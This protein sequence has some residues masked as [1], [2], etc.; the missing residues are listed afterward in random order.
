MFEHDKDLSRYT[1]FGIPAKA[2]LFAEYSS[3]KELLALSRKPEFTDN[4]ILHIGGGS[5]LLFVNDFDGLVLHSAIKGITAYKKNDGDIFVIAGA[6]EKWAD[7]VDWCVDHDL[8]GMECMAGIPGEVGAAPVQNVG[9]YGSEAQDVIHSVECF[10][11]QTRKTVTLFN[12]L[13]GAGK[14]K[15]SEAPAG[16]DPDNILGFGYRDSNFKKDWKGRF[17]VLRVSF[18]LSPGTVASNLRYDALRK[19]EERL[20]RCPSIRE[21]R[22]EVIALRNSKLPDPAVIGSAGSFFKNPVVHK[23]FYA[24]EVLRRCP[25][26]PAHEVDYRLVKLPAGWLIEHAGLKGFSIGGAQ[27]YPANCLVIA[28]TGNATAEDVT[29]LA[30]HVADTVNRKFGVRLLPEVNYIDDSITVTIL[31]SGTSK[32]IPEVGCQCHVCSSDDAADKRL[33]ASATVDTMGVKLLIDPSPDFRQQALAANI[34]RLDAVLV[35]HIHYDH[36]GGLDDL[37]PFCLES[38]IPLY[39]RPE[40]ISDLKRRL[41]YCFRN[42]R[43]PGIPTFNVHEIGNLPFHVKGVTIIPI[44]VM[45]GKLPIVGYRIGNFAYI[46]DCKTLPEEEFDKLENLDTLVINALRDRDHFAHLTIEEALALIKRIN[47]RRAYLTHLCHEAGTHAELTARMPE[48]VFP[49]YDGL[50]ISINPQV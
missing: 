42:D 6:G 44:N 7:L 24:D 33:R 4:E 12:T 49:A 40:V 17:I 21:V 18:R 38:D 23:N 39:A 48:N 34:S 50:V 25:D 31:G 20:G 43:Y 8:A 15:P 35:T 28:N 26:V 45:H 22:D 19:L 9:A 5:N 10:D 36:V 27:V 1:T 13:A 47:P 32:G 11:I 14:G 37:R 46:T 29:R 3:E 30:A 41:D 16:A 2:R